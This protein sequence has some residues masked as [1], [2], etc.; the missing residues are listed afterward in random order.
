METARK[1]D[2]AEIGA[3]LKQLLAKQ[4]TLLAL[5]GQPGTHIMTSEGNIESTPSPA[6][7][8]TIFSLL[9]DI[10][11]VRALYKVIYLY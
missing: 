3:A 7:R 6:T 8:T 5:V 2:Q 11:D 1:E 9:A 10:Q 4:D